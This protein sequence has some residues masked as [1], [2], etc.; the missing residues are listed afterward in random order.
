MTDRPKI[1]TVSG[2]P[3][4]GTTT[5]AGRLGLLLAV[6]AISTGAVFRQ[7]AAEQGITLEELGH[8][9]DRDP[10]ID[11]DLDRRML[12]LVAATG[13]CVAEGR[14]AG[15]LVPDATLRVW[16]HAP[17]RVRA[18]RVGTRSDESLVAMVAREQ[19][20]IRRYRENYHVEI[21]RCET[22]D[23]CLDTARF[24]AATVASLVMGAISARLAAQIREIP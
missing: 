22:Y 18:A 6:P 20:E 21:D 5:L 2:Y 15:A 13:D 17:T 16:L 3:G 23:I 19:H 10:E 7:M 12:A 4:S 9:A 24:D 11:F 8:R 14:L 1:I